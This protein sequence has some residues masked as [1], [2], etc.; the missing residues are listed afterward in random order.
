MPVSSSHL[1]YDN[2]L[3]SWSR[4]RDVMIGDAAVKAAGD[5]Y[6]PRLDSQTDD[7]FQ[8]YVSRGLFYNATARTVSGYIGMIFR[9]DPVLQLPDNSAP[10]NA[11]LKTFA[12]DV[13]LLG[14]TL[15]SYSKRIV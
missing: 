7:E 13:D 5:K 3:D 12:N 6:V 10:V 4:I 15:N 14:T 2:N 1:D 11:L 9:R 8:A